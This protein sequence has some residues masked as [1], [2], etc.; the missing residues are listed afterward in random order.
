MKRGKRRW[1]RR[2]SVEEDGRGRTPG[3]GG[4][5]LEAGCGC[6]GRGEGVMVRDTRDGRQKAGGWTRMRWR[7]E[8]GDGGRGRQA[9]TGCRRRGRT[10][11]S[12]V[13]GSGV[14]EKGGGR[15][16]WISRFLKRNN[17]FYKR[18][19]D[20]KTIATHVFLKIA[21]LQR[22]CGDDSPHYCSERR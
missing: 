1:A 18:P 11:G 4:G 12:P 22:A 15:R 20:D 5:R 14:R 17:S 6:R 21:D 7:R 9:R 3:A 13:P 8:Q 19:V 16:A 2:E 10:C